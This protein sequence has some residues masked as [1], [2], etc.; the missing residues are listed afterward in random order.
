MR[1]K[2]KLAL[3]LRGLPHAAPIG[4]R[5]HAVGFCPKPCPGADPLSQRST[6]SGR[7]LDFLAQ[8]RPLRDLLWLV[9]SRSRSMRC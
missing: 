2:E 5:G 8:G 6:C 1:F 3:T 4:A 9:G 7:I